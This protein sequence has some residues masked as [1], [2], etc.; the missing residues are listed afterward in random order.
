MYNIIII[1]SYQ[2]LVIALRLAF[3]SIIIHWLLSFSF[4]R[5]HFRVLF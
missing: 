4:F 2:Q 1:F 5:C 3:Q